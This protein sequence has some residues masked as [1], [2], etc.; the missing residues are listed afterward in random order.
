MPELPEVE[1]VRR[2]LEPALVGHKISRLD[3]NRP[4]LRF[5]FPAKFRARLEGLAG[6]GAWMSFIVVLMMTF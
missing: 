6:H 4:D 1:T 5:P 2:G 3:V